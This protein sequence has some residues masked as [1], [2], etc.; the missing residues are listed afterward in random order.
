MSN[1]QSG[2]AFE[3]GMALEIAQWIQAELSMDRSMQVAYDYFNA[4]DSIEQS[5]ITNASKQ[6]ASFLAAR[7]TRLAHHK[8]KIRIQSDMHGAKGD[9]RDIIIETP[10][11]E[12]GISAKNRHHAVKHSRLSERIDFG[13]QWMGQE[14]SSDYYREISPIFRELRSRREQRQLW[15]DIPDKKDRFYLPILHAFDRELN[16]L[17]ESD[18]AKIA[19]KLLHYLLGE[20]DYYKIAK[21]NGRVSI[22]SFN[23]D[24]SLQWGARLPLPGTLINTDIKNKTTLMVVFDKGWQLSFRIHSASSR[25]EPSLKFDIQI[26]GLPFVL[27]R[28]ETDY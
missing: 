12:V 15:R 21:I 26:I 24:G 28:H 13:K 4:C 10:S 1:V 2:R 9:V 6:I 23:I 19:K 20:H 22:Q 27:T 25:V 14:S 18:D 16:R 5:K 8:C 3:Y 7:D 11:G 17:Y